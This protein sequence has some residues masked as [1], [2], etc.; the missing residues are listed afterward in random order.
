MSEPI[1]PE[2]ALLSALLERKSHPADKDASALNALVR[3]MEAGVADGAAHIQFEHICALARSS[4][5][6]REPA[7]AEILANPAS[8]IL[9]R[10]MLRAFR[11][12]LARDASSK[13]SSE[14]ARILAQSMQGW[15][16]AG[17][18]S[19]SRTR[20]DIERCEE[21]GRDAFQARLI[22]EL[23][24]GSVDSQARELAHADALVAAYK[25][26]MVGYKKQNTTDRALT[27][28]QLR[29]LLVVDG[30]GPSSHVAG[31][32]GKVNLPP[33]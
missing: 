4:F 30:C 11:N 25:G 22:R 18:R 20:E 31:E 6:E 26:Y 24:M 10:F 9:V 33:D 32:R 14:R 8:P 5:P 28:S 1:K 19:V 17:R 27:M 7:D 21:A 23:L 2:D 15:G 3:D 29:E 12:Y 16:D 13:N